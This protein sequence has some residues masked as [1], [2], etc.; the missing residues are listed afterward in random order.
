MDVDSEGRDARSSSEAEENE[1]G[2]DGIMKADV[3][4]D[5]LD[6]A[7]EAMTYQF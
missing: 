2:L 4:R 6:A 5:G 7:G 1:A 3:E